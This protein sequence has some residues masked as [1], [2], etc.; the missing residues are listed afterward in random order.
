MKIKIASVTVEDQ[1]R[2]LQFYTGVLGFVKQKD[3]PA[4]SYRWLTV[5]APDNPE[6]ELLLE[7]GAFPPAK[8]YQKAL[9]G[10]GIPATM[11][12]VDD[13]AA[14]HA[15]LEKAGVAFRMGPTPAGPVKIAMFDDTCGNYIQIVQM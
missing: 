2:A 14:E 8:V 9:F 3:V 1:E 15:R 13:I 11:F 12:F 4:G 7:P 6:V 5:A 10:A